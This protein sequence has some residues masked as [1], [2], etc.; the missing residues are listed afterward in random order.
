[1]S[2][3]HVLTDIT[4]RIQETSGQ[5]ACG[6]YV[7]FKMFLIQFDTTVPQGTV[8]GPLLF[9]IYINDLNQAIKFRKVQNFENNT[10]LLLVDNSL[11]KLNKHINHDLKLPAT[12]S[13]QTQYL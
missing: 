5:H 4:N 11:K 3:N 10:N 2:T 12:W 1:M 9:L 8:L 7:D 6:I 13:E